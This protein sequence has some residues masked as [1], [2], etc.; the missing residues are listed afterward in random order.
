[1]SK[2]KTISIVLAFM[3]LTVA[4]TAAITQGFKEWNPYGWFSKECVHEYGEDGLCTKC[5]EEKPAENTDTG[6]LYIN[7]SLVT[8]KGVKLSMSRVMAPLSSEVAATQSLQTTYVINAVATPTGSGENN[9]EWAIEN[10]EDGA[11]TTTVSEDTL[12]CT[13][14]CNAAFSTQKIVTVSVIGNPDVSASVT[15]DYL[16]RVTAVSVSNKTFAFQNY[17]SNYILTPVPTYSE[18]TITPTVTITGGTM[19]F[20]TAFL[21]ENSNFEGNGAATW[22]GKGTVTLSGASAPSLYLGTDGSCFGLNVSSGDESYAKSAYYNSVVKAINEYT[23]NHYYVEFNWKATYGDIV[24]EGTGRIE[25]RFDVT[26]LTTVNSLTT[27][28]DS[29]VF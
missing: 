19:G 13:V 28:K 18:G 16:K 5:G 1:M 8:S 6:S 14:T 11:I 27:N 2:V 21:A 3:L 25:G 17:P 7:E 12:S 4:V 9:L 23:G 10:N 26:N 24:F 20:T 22:N 29:V 15:L